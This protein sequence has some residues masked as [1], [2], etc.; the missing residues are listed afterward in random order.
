MIPSCITWSGVCR[1]PWGPYFTA[2]WG[3]SV[4]DTSKELYWFASTQ[5]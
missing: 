5:L 1:L 3:F 2:Y 4:Y